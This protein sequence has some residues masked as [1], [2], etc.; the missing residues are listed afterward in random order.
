MSEGNDMKSIASVVLGVPE[1]KLDRG[2][3]L[4]YLS[5]NRSNMH[6][7]SLSENAHDLFRTMLD[8]IML[9]IVAIFL[10]TL[11]GFPVLAHRILAVHEHVLCRSRSLQSR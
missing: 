11:P 8:S 6:S 10:A 2:I 7:H 5:L 3:Y 1:W 4:G 9:A